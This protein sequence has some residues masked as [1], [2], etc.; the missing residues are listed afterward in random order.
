MVFQNGRP[1]ELKSSRI[2][3]AVEQA[4]CSG[5]VVRGVFYY[6]NYNRHLQKLIQH[7]VPEVCRDDRLHGCSQLAL[8]DGFRRRLMVHRL[9]SIHHDDHHNVSPTLRNG[10]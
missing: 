7:R 4:L 5:H 2:V 6:T 8:P 9:R 3:Y 1:S 10:P